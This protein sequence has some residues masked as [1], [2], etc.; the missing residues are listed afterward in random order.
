M[1]LPF[2]D[3]PVRYYEHSSGGGEQNG[4]HWNEAASVLQLAWG[5]GGG[6]RRARANCRGQFAALTGA[7]G[8]R[9]LAAILLWSAPRS[10]QA[11]RTRIWRRRPLLRAA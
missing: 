2:R 10:P 5:L 7:A 6:G 1:S 8:A 3:G 4:L 11:V 9:H